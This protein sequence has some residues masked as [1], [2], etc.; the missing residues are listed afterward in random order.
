MT[1][2]DK[3]IEDVFAEFDDLAFFDSRD[4]SL[5]RKIYQLARRQGA[6]EQRVN[7]RKVESVFWIAWSCV[8]FK[9]DRDRLGKMFN[10]AIA[11]AE[12][13]LTEGKIRTQGLDCK[14]GLT[15]TEQSDGQKYCSACNGS[16]EQP[17]EVSFSGMEGCVRCNGTGEEGWK[18]G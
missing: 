4:W 17:S 5:A 8:P 18:E 12:S 9:I 14:E 10:E 2:E 15:G 1:N 11:N 6:A 13:K 7:F 3:I 16:G